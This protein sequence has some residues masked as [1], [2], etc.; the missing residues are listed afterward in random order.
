MTKMI[1]FKTYK[2]Y[3]FVMDVNNKRIRIHIR[4]NSYTDSYYMNVDRLNQ[5]L[6]ENIINSIALV[7]GVDLFL[8][9]PQFDLGEFW[10]VPFKTDYYSESPKASTIQNF[11]IWSVSRD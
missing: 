4:Y 7:T 3:N 10:V 1:Q 9:H 8:Q 2:P 11:V 5:G 6:Y